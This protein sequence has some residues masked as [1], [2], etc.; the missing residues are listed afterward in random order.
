MSLKPKMG[1]IIDANINRFKEGARVLEDIARFVFQDEALFQKIKALKNS[2]RVTQ[3]M[4]ESDADPG[5]AHFVEKNQRHGLM[6]IIHANAVRMQ[7]AA[8]SLEECQDSAVYKNLRFEAYNVHSDMV[9]ACHAFQNTE[10]LNGIYMIC[11]PLRQSVESIEKAIQKETISICQIRI[12][13]QTPP[14]I[15]EQARK[16][17]PIC[18]EHQCLLIINDSVDIAL[19]CADGVHLGQDDFP[20]AACR[21]IVPEHFIVGATCRSVEAALKAEKE[22]ASYISVGCLFETKTKENAI[23]TSLETLKAIVQA[24]NI[25]V[26]G[27]GGINQTN[28]QT[29]WETGV[30]MVGLSNGLFS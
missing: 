11:D 28:I 6:D 24:V 16:L 29:V 30:A 10:K 23:P 15:L 8:R 14:V 18:E 22:G 1:Y 26:C 13:Q 27:I 20:I 7:E 9:Q 19:A 21:Q 5:G 25:P 17:K 4:R 3:V 12:K 2:I